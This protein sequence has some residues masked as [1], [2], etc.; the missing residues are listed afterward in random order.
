MIPTEQ[1]AQEQREKYI[2]AFNS[3]MIQIWQE[4]ITLLDVI[5]TGALL[6]SPISLP[7]RADGRFF[8]VTLS[9]SFLEYGLWQDYGVGRETPKGMKA[10]SSV[11]SE[12]ST[13]AIAEERPSGS[14]RTPCGDLARAKKRQRRPWFSRKYYASVL[15]LR[16]FLGDNIGKE[17]QGIIADT[18]ARTNK[19]Y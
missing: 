11:W 3:T 5:D 10:N 16:D 12:E 9:Q 6:S 14:F 15:N 1:A 18:F 19:I 17:F 2:L 7:V 13:H 4:R 8:E